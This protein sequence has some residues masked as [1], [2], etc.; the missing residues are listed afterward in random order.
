MGTSRSSLALLLGAVSLIG[1][2]ASSPSAGESPSDLHPRME[3]RLAE[4]LEADRHGGEHALLAKGAER[5]IPVDQGRVEVSIQP[6]PGK[7]SEA[8]DIAALRRL[9]FVTRTRS[10]TLV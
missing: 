2:A 9:G 10:R 5:G 6:A 3:W 8:I 1:A 7:G 4:L